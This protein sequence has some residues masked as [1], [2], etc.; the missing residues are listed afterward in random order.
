M[1]RSNLE[2]SFTAE[3]FAKLLTVS[4]VIEKLQPGSI[5]YLCQTASLLADNWNITSNA[6]NIERA[7]KVIQEFQDWL[8]SMSEPG[9]DESPNEEYHTL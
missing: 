8:D 6:N 9:R 2:S 3:Q 4:M 1:I 7:R 5:N